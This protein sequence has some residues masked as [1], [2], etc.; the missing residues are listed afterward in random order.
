[1]MVTAILA[2][3]SRAM[4]IRLRVTHTAIEPGGISPSPVKGLR[5]ENSLDRSLQKSTSLELRDTDLAWGPVNLLNNLRELS[6]LFLVALQQEEWLDA[7]MLAAGMN[8]IAED[9][10]HRDLFRLARVAQYASHLPM[11]FGLAAAGLLRI[12]HGSLIRIWRCAPGIRR[13][14]KWQSLWAEV[15]QFLARASLDD[16]AVTRGAET[17]SLARELVTQLECLPPKILVQVLRLPSCFRSF[18]QEPCDLDKIVAEFC[19]RYPDRGRPLVVIGLR[20]SGSYL[21]PLCAA[22]LMKHGFEHVSSL[23]LRPG[24][25]L[26]RSERLILQDATTHAGYVLPIDDPPETG[27]TL[28]QAC[29]ELE[30]AGVPSQTIILLLQLFGPV[31]SLPVSL[32]KYASI[33][34]PWK[35]WTIHSKLEPN[36]VRVALSELMAPSVTVEQV[37]VISPPASRGRRAHAHGVYRVRVVDL[38]TGLPSDRLVFAKGAGL[39][40][41][42]R[43]SLTVAQQLN[44]FVPNIYGLKDGVLFREWLPEERRLPPILEGDTERLANAMA[45]YVAARNAVLTVPEDV[46]LRLTG[47]SPV[48]E[49]ASNALAHVFRRAWLPARVLIV[50]AIVQRL[51]QVERSSIIDGSM[52]FS[53]W[54]V[55][56]DHS[57]LLRKIDFDERAFS[58]KDLYCYDPVFDLVGA[59]IGYSPES[60]HLGEELRRAYERMSNQTITGE[61]WLLYELVHLWDLQRSGK[62]MTPLAE[63][64]LS[65]A[66]QD[67]YAGV[68]FREI[69]FPTEGPICAVDID[70]VL[71]TEQLGIPSITPAGAT[72]LRALLQHGYRPVL[73]SGRSL[74]QVRERCMAYRLPGGCAE[75]GAV[76]YNH[77]T[78]DE[79]SLLSAS[80][81]ADLDRLRSVLGKIRRIHLDPE[82]KHAI[83]A[84]RMDG[85][86]RQCGLAY[87]FAQ[88]AVA[89]A[90]LQ[91]R[92]RLIMGEKQTDFMVL[93]IDKGVGLRELLNDL[94]GVGVRGSKPL[95]LAVGDTAS[96][97]PFLELAR[98]ASAP[99]NAD[100]AVRRA[101]IPIEWRPYQSGFS[102]AVAR[103]LGHKPGSC[104]I[105]HGPSLSRES[106]LFIRTLGVQDKDRVGA[107]LEAF[108]L[109][110]ATR[111]I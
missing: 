23:T 44:G 13:L 57:A 11:P 85:S 64:E 88:Q 12:L 62:N 4:R 8:Q 10:I 37:E 29:A 84:F 6:R 28:A 103:R 27:G 73:V 91:N 72:A 82:F 34:L 67:Y 39:G 87:E 55:G 71:E 104:S 70:G 60:A 111:E 90:G 106:A 52:S 5:R 46:S 77:I 59:A 16:N 38:A 83:R 25:R 14:F 31:E 68:Y 86:G 18:D 97:L 66:F 20:T 80:E 109:A 102:Q 7:F 63:R 35:E 92:I 76:T 42:G 78:G 24:R 43:H 26:L 98:Q 47:Q 19:R 61:R 99:A 75:Y 100:G 93:R 54:F 101:G 110:R 56:D 107:L 2:R 41:F 51:L 40:Y 36:A 48:W 3:A 30:Q 95:A 89:D 15:V 17:L 1:M 94:G 33:L 21:A 79:K 22:L 74:E 49:I 108:W 9:Y 81:Q 50:D 45:A 32:S 105:C 69:P 65:R 58:N 53:H 96:D